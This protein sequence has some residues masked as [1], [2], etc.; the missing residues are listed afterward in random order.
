MTKR[1]IERYFYRNGQIR[2]M[3]RLTDG[4][5]QGV[6]RAWHYNGQLAEETRYRNGK[7]H[8]TSRQWNAKGQLIGSFTMDHGTGTMRQWYQD[9]RLCSEADLLHGK[10]H[11]R[12]RTWLRDG[13]LVQEIFCIGN[14]DATRAAYLKA[15]KDHPDWPQYKGQSAGRVARETA[16]LE[17][18]HYE[19]YVESLLEKSHAEAGKWLAEATRPDM[20]SLARFR[21]PG[22]ALRFVKAIYEA[23]AVAAI[24]VPIYAGKRGKQF[25]D[26]LLIKLPQTRTNRKVLRKLCQNCC[27]KRGGAMMPEKDIGERYLLL[28][29]E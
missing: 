26:L 28:H 2:I 27:D 13:T 18:K 12:I 10:F 15:A 8:G 11:G 4:K 3:N 9:G 29:L 22:V 16:A 14:S 19:L 17:C 20:R 7:L 21:T 5:F 23:G 1:R 6:S 24:A 25:A